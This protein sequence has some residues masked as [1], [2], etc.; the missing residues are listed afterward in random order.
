M[1][2]QTDML[3]KSE[4]VTTLEKAIK[5]AEAFKSAVRDQSRSLEY[6]YYL[7]AISI[8]TFLEDRSKWSMKIWRDNRYFGGKLEISFVH[9]PPTF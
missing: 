7:Q 2:I 1:M 8:L 3:A 6:L 5:H 4:S 9:G